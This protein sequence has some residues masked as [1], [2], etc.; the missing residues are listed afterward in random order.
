MKALFKSFLV[1]VLLFFYSESLSSQ[2]TGGRFFFSRL[3]SLDWDNSIIRPGTRS[4]KNNSDITPADHYRSGFHTSWLL[5]CKLNKKWSLTSGFVYYRYSIDSWVRYSSYTKYGQ[6]IEEKSYTEKR[7]FDF[8]GLPLFVSYNFASADDFCFVA[9][10]GGSYL[11][12]TVLA[13]GALGFLYRDSPYMSISFKLNS[14]C[15]LIPLSTKQDKRMYPYSIGYEF[16][17]S[18]TLGK[19]RS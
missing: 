7:T 17:I 18:L 13:T 6:L 11:G 5:T 2:I 10:L 19:V 14:N 4:T 12:E 1:A 16:G 9:D 8:P 15:F 3:I